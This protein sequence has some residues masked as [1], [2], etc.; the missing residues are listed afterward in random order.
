MSNFGDIIN[1]GKQSSKLESQDTGKPASQSSSK[2]KKNTKTETL[3]DDPTVSLTIKVPKSLRKHWTISAK[4]ED[5]SV[6]AVIVEALS[7]RFG[8]P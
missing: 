1:Q 4:Q 6:A 5:T 3:V 2:V 7:K 8:T